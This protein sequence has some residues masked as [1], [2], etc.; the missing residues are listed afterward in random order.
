MFFQYSFILVNN[1][2]HYSWFRIEL[3]EQE[4][5]A[6]LIRLYLL[7]PVETDIFKR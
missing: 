2:P 7:L 4:S 6:W 1:L 3:N 5:L